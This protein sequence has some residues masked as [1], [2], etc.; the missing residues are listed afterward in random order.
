VLNNRSI[1]TALT[2]GSHNMLFTADVEAEALTRMSR[3]ASPSP[4]ELLKVPHHGAA[5]SLDR[6]WLERVKPRYAVISVGRHNPYGHPAPAVLQAYADR[7][8]ALYRTDRDGGVWVTGT[9]LS[10]ELQIQE[11][12]QQQPQR[13]PFTS[14]LWSCERSNWKRLIARWTD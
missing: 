13:V 4:V 6:E 3:D 14:C 11:T 2:C 7:G 12:R 8:T 1:V 9:W 10:P 5:G